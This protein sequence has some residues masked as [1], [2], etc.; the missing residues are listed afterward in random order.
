MQRFFYQ[1]TSLHEILIPAAVEAIKDSSSSGCS[2]FWR[3]RR[4]A[5]ESKRLCA[6][7]SMR[8][9]V[10]SWGAWD[11]PECELPSF[12]MYTIPGRVGLVR[13]R[14]WQTEI[15]GMLREHSL[16]LIQCCGFVSWSHWFQAFP[17]W[18]FE[19]ASML[20]E[21]AIWKPNIIDNYLTG[22]MDLRPLIL[23]RCNV[24]LI[25]SQWLPLLFQMFSPS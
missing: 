3:V 14:K 9:W 19:D 25:L 22:T 8:D 12:V 2:S 24:V 7:G 13:S 5:M 18:K 11:I 23:W 10:G 16:V 20:L 6:A 15:H 21:L 1:C 4:S 17:V